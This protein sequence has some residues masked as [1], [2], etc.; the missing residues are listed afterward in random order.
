VKVCE[1]S[2]TTLDVEHTSVNFEDRLYKKIFDANEFSVDTFTLKCKKYQFGQKGHRYISISQ[3]VNIKYLEQLFQDYTYSS[4][5]IS[6]KD[7]RYENKPINKCFTVLP[8]SSTTSHC[9]TQVMKGKLV[10]KGPCSVKFYHVASKDLTQCPFIAII[11]IGNE[12][13]LS[14]TTRKLL[15]KPMLK[16]YL[17]G[18]PLSSLHPLLNN[19]SR[20]TY[21]IKK[22]KRSKYPFGQDII[23][24]AHELLKQ[25]KLPDPYICLQAELLSQSSYIEID[26]AFKRIHDVTNEWEVC[27]YVHHYQK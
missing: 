2:S 9:H 15:T 8:N 24:V 4:N 3:C 26:I 11:S 17:Q 13:D 1:F 21:L 10:N 27:V 6:R 12:H 19:Q 23:G 16:I 5:K 18:Q 25:K 22:N 14:L 7:Y 20:L